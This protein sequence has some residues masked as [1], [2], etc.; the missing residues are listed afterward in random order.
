VSTDLTVATETPP[1]RPRRRGGL[2]WPA[3]R[4]IA[5]SVGTAL[6]AQPVPLAQ[7]VGRRLASDLV[8]RAPLP[9]A[10]LS[11]MDGWAVVGPPP[12]QVVGDLPAGTLPTR[13]IA[14]GECVRIATGAVVPHGTYAVLPVEHAVH[15]GQEVRPFG[16]A[17]PPSRRHVRPAGEEALAGDL[18]LPAGTRVTPPVVGLAAATGHDTLHVDG[19]ATVAVLVLGDELTNLGV[20]TRG[21]TRDALGPQLPG[22]LTALGTAPPHVRRLPDRLE[23]LTTAVRTSQATIVLTTGGTGVGPHDHVRTAIQDLGG[24]LLVDGVDVKPGHPMLLAALPDGRFLAGLPGN[25]LAACVALLTLVHPL[26]ARLHNTTSPPLTTVRLTSHE[27]AR[28]GDGHRLLPVRRIDDRAEVLPS[29]GSAM[30]RGLAA[31]TGLAVVAPGGTRSG[32]EV[33]YLPLPW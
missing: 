32:D 24:V 14:A 16:H 1:A 18:L 11:A 8:A 4:A 29:C 26:I 12:W 28:D 30:L 19:I 6:L 13:A 21:R 2:P 27:P 31:A 20:P 15:I 23:A 33:S 17:W 3:A 5:G 10:D 22:W 9:S 7:A 25:P